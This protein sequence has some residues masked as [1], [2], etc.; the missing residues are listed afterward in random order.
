MLTIAVTNTKGGVGKT[1]LA[2]SLAVRA[3]QDKFTGGAPYRVALVDLDP[4]RDLAAASPDL[5]RSRMRSRSNSTRPAMMVR[6]SLPFAVLR[7]KLSAVCART[8]TF[9]L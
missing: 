8:L 1:T 7:S 6:I 2:A 9:Q 3:A 4:M 5:T